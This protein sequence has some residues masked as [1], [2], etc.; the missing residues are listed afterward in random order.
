MKDYCNEIAILD[1][2]ITR[3]PEQASQWEARRDKAIK[4]L[5]AQQ[6]CERKALEKAK[7]KAEKVKQKEE[8]VYK[9]QVR[10]Q[11]K[12]SLASTAIAVERITT[13][14]GD[15]APGSV[16]PPC[17]VL[18]SVALPKMGRLALPAMC[19]LTEYSAVIMMMPALSLIHI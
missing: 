7:Q 10:Y 9:R 18:N 8:D 4:L 2:G 3:M 14:Y 13:V 12:S 16:K 5:F 11:S 1:E 19:R 6:E 15:S 17:A